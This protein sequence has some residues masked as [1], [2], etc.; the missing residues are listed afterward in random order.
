MRLRT[1]IILVVGLAAGS[2]AWG[3]S[4]HYLDCSAGNDAADSLTPQTAW[5]SIEKANSFAYQPGDRLLLRRGTRCEGMLWPK[6]SGTE[7]AP[8]RLAAYGD[9]ALPVIVGGAESA[10]LRLHNQEYWEIENLEIV[11]GSPYGIHIGGTQPLL[12]H[13]RITNVVVHDVTGKPLTKDSG[14][15]VIAPDDKSMT[16][17][18]DVIIDG[19][20]AY[21]ATEWAGIIVNGAGFDAGGHQDHGD[22]IEIRNSVVHDVAGDGILLARVMHGVIEHNVAWYTGMQETESIGTPNAIWEWRCIDCRVEYNEAYFSDSP[23]VDGGTF[24]IDY[25]DEKNVVAHNFGHDSQGYCVSVFGAEGSNGDSTESV[26]RDNTCIHNGRSPRLARRQGA[27]FLYT[28]NGGEL[29]GVDIEHN[30]I[31]WDPELDAAAFQSTAAFKDGL[32]NR[33]L[34]NTVISPSGEFAALSTTFQFSGNHYCG[35]DKPPEHAPAAVPANSDPSSSNPE[36]V[37]SCLQKLSS[38]AGSKESTA[39]EIPLSGAGKAAR[40]GSWT[41]VA[42][43]APPGDPQAAASRSELVVI[44]S[45]SHQFADIGL[46]TVV[47][48]SRAIAQEALLVW[49]KDWNFDSSIQFDLKDAQ[50]IRGNS[51]AEPT[52][53]LVSP[54]GQVAASWKSPVLPAEVWLQIESKLG[55]PRGTQAIPSCAS[56]R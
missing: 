29:N 24:D 53:L 3:Q 32:P 48:P 30:T 12:R 42:L 31:L 10:G 38:T 52:M 26:I 1:F 50:G 56:S 54:S 33:F 23:G 37:C 44:E 35:R 13:F 2:S 7:K 55:A 14:L 4:T 45:M 34:D 19:V 5:R 27:I 11:G 8:I 43:L 49:Q 28:W 46:M 9:G 21:G 40:S 51:A 22:H 15:I 20:T 16:R 6:G 41:L 36:S 18:E 25:G 39:G 47:V 17:I